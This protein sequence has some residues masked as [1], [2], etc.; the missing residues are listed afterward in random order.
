MHVAFLT[1]EYPHQLCNA[2]GGLGTSI[3][4]LAESLVR[5]GEEVSLII[6]GQKEE[7][8]FEESGI[9]FYLIKQKSY[10]WG[11]WFFYRKYIQ[12]F[13][14]KLISDKNIQIIEAPD[15]TGITALMNISCPVVIRM[16]GSDAY[17]CELDG[18]QQK[19]K[20]RF[21]EKKALKSA[22]S[23]VSV[24]AFTARKTNEILGL[25]RHI[26]IIP[27]SIRIDEFGPSVEKPVPN[28][29]LYFGTLIR[30][31]GVLELAHIFNHVNSVLPDA[32][33]ILIGKDVPDI[34]EKRSTLEIFQEKLIENAKQK[35]KYIGAVSYDEVKTYIKEAV[36]VVLPSFAEALPMTWLEAMA[37]EKAL[38]TSNIGWA[39]EVM[40]DGKTGFTVSPENHQLY[41]E[42]IIELLGNPDLSKEMGANARIKVLDDFSSD[43]VAERNIAYY[44]SV[45][46]K[47]LNN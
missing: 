29:I 9:H 30:K 38:V 11:G 10:F 47:Y 34:F 4:N 17:F 24:S 46:D 37:M 8:N 26:K 12:R 13:I 44:N 41:A 14:N 2:S 21:F 18:R 20:N 5:K 31:K 39:K 1:P 45:L 19:P 42:R 35:V 40:I 6:Y 36:V 32:E 16:N 23:L 15:W 43:V 33:L 25:K 3:K 28:R 27:N 22:D 7:S